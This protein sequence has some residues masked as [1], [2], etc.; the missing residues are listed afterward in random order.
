MEKKLNLRQLQHKATLEAIRSAVDKMVDSVG[1]DAMT[2]RDICKE[3]DITVGTFY[4]YF[5]SKNELLKDRYIRSNEHFQTY[6]EENLA[7]LDELEALRL[8]FDHYFEYSGTRVY[9]LYKRFMQVRIDEYE[10]WSETDPDRIRGL[11]LEIIIS[12][13]KKGSIRND[14]SAEDMAEFINILLQG[15][16][17]TYVTYDR[18]APERT[19]VKAIIRECIDSLGANGSSGR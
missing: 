11:I 19:G 14:R 8:F 10:K 17:T 4:H 18:E 6:Y 2:I 3:V 16:T 7:S 15:F 5:S 1:F 9:Q 12:G 13:Q